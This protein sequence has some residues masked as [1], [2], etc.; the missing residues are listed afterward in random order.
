[1]LDETRVVIVDPVAIVRR[2]TLAY[3]VEW[4]SVPLAPRRAMPAPLVPA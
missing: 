3:R 2:H 4:V 1:M